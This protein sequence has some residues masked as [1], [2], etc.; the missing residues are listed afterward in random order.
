MRSAVTRLKVIAAILEKRGADMSAVQEL[1]QVAEERAIQHKDPD[2]TG[3]SNCQ[4]PEVA[5]PTSTEESFRQHVNRGHLPWRRDCRACL[6]AAAYHHACRRQ[7]H[8]H[9]F[10]LCLDLC[11]PYKAGSDQAGLC[12]LGLVGV[13]T[14]PKCWDNGRPIVGESTMGG[15]PEEADPDEGEQPTKD[16]PLKR[17]PEDHPIPEEFP[18]DDLPDIDGEPQDD[19]EPSEEDVKAADKAD[20]KWKAIV[21]ASLDP[22]PMIRIPVFEV[23]YKK[24][25]SPVCQAVSQIYLRIKRLG[26]PLHRVHTDRGKEF[27][28]TSFRI[29]CLARDLMWT[30]TSSDLPQSSG[31]AERY[32]GIIKQQARALLRHSGLEIVHW[33]SAMRYATYS[34]YRQAVKPLGVPARSIYPFGATV[35]IREKAWRV[36]NWSVR[37]VQGRILAPAIDVSKGWIVLVVRSDGKP[38]MLISTLC[39]SEVRE[40]PAVELGKD[41]PAD[42]VPLSMHPGDNPSAH[43]EGEVP[44]TSRPRHHVTATSGPMTGSKIPTRRVTGKASLRHARV[45]SQGGGPN[46][47]LAEVAGP[48]ETGPGEMTRVWYAE[49]LQEESH[50]VC[51]VRCLDASESTA[52]QMQE[53][54][55]IPRDGLR[56]LLTECEWQRSQEVSHELKELGVI[57]LFAEARMYGITPETYERPELTKLLCQYVQQVVPSALFASIVIT[58]GFESTWRRDFSTHDGSVKWVIPVGVFSIRVLEEG[59]DLDEANECEFRGLSLDISAG[60]QEFNPRRRHASMPYEG[61]RLLLTAFSPQSIQH[62]SSEEVAELKGLG[63]RPPPLSRR[64]L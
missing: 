20:A 11:G 8:P 53:Q 3:F 40:P 43:A 19:L 64:A 52:K 42:A 56:D 10:S 7:K 36:K 35:Y 46:A 62:L 24:K 49:P 14:F 16:K 61:Q 27:L 55:P 26:L 4:V 21:K 54:N 22:L 9:A 50:K 2:D 30:T 57:G 33:P 39:Y 32:V 34:L 31:L 51:L 47:E 28:N 48:G 63:F 44:D 41:N 29:W 6:E 13:Y 1:C 15:V 12:R 17:V 38:A 23:V 58:E 60:P 5:K 25:P 18:D 45:L 37:A 59:I